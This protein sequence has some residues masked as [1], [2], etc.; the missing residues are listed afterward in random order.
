MLTTKQ[1]ISAAI[2]QSWEDPEVRSMRTKGVQKSWQDPKVR[3][4]HKAGTRRWRESPEAIARAERYQ[5]KLAEPSIRAKARQK[6]QDELLAKHIALFNEAKPADHAERLPLIV[7]ARRDG[8]T[9]EGI[10]TIHNLTRQRIQQILSP[11]L[12]REL[13]RREKQKA[14]QALIAK[15]AKLLKSKTPATRDDCAKQILDAKGA[16]LTWL[17]LGEI[18]GVKWTVVRQIAH[19]PD[20]QYKIDWKTRLGFL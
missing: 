16:G 19:Y 14:K 8:L 12:S 7:A 9:L 10:G 11:P 17:D 2:K 20:T 18:Y 6:Q 1:K 3:A 13:P 4:R 5:A 15:Y